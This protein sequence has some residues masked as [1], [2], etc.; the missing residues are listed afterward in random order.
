MKFGIRL[1]YRYLTGSKMSCLE[2]AKNFVQEHFLEKGGKGFSS[3]VRFYYRKMLLF[4][5]PPNF[6]F[7]NI[8]ELI[9]IDVFLE[10]HFKNN[11]LEYLILEILIQILFLIFW[12][13]MVYKMKMLK[14]IT[15][16]NNMLKWINNVFECAN[17]LILQQTSW[18]IV[19]FFL[20]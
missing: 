3:V 7:L 8:E 4:S 5:R 11:L 1:N 14:S 17:V 19:K 9:K 16:Q 13:R 15:N 6:Y 2:T 10:D 20:N 18:W 12:F